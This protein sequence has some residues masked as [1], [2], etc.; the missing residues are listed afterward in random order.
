MVHAPWPDQPRRP[1]SRRHEPRPYLVERPRRYEPAQ[2]QYDRDDPGEVAAATL[3]EAGRVLSAL[4]PRLRDAGIDQRIA[5][6]LLCYPPTGHGLRIFKI[7]ERL[8]VAPGT[9]SRWVDEA[10]TR[11]L[12][13]KH[14]PDVIDRRATWTRLTRPG[15][16]ARAEVIA[17]LRDAVTKPRPKLFAYGRRSYLESLRPKS[18]KWPKWPR[19]RAPRLKRPAAPPGS[20]AP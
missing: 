8:G 1:R 6:V 16:A 4:R 19:R 18:P 7:A 12:V 9:A 10:E 20:P 17:L 5:R 15:W 11:A 3:A 2:R 13:D 14:Y